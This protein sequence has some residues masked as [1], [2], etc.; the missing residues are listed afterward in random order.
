MAVNMMMDH[1]NVSPKHGEGLHPPPPPRPLIVKTN[2][3][4]SSYKYNALYLQFFITAYDRTLFSLS[5]THTHSLSLSLS[6]SVARA[7][8]LSLSLSLSLSH[9]PIKRKNKQ[10]LFLQES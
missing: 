6:L 10:K 7:R 5:H 3:Y 2:I 8:A 9:P 1:Y 4:I